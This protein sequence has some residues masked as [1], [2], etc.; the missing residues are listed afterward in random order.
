MIG[1]LLTAALVLQALAAEVKQ[2]G[3][4]GGT[5]LMQKRNMLETTRGIKE[6][7]DSDTDGM[8]KALSQEV[9]EEGHSDADDPEKADAQ[10]LQERGFN[11]SDARLQEEGFGYPWEFQ[12]ERARRAALLR[13]GGHWERMSASLHLNYN[14][15]AA[16]LPLKETRWLYTDFVSSKVAKNE[17]W[18]TF[19][20]RL[21]YV[22]YQTKVDHAG[23]QYSQFQCSNW[24]SKG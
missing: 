22:G 14:F 21:G 11:A 1:A 13:L 15:N 7:E 6:E 5:C 17:Y 23:R 2:D 4:S 9:R 16:G 10:L 8:A 12:R 24:D 20:H 19:T 3:N 18:A